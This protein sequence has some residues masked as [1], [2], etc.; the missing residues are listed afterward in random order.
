MLVLRQ[1]STGT[2]V[3]GVAEAQILELDVVKA[4]EK[5]VQHQALK[6]NMKVVQRVLQMAVVVVMV[7]VARFP[8]HIGT[9]P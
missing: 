1:A 5:G 9:L 6:V 2:L 4:M 3:P 8:M 7:M